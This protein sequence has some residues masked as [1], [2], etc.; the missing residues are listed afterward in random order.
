M[1]GEAL[2]GMAGGGAGAG[3]GAAAGGGGAACGGAP[4][5][6]EVGQA[7]ARLGRVGQDRL[8]R[9]G[10]AR[11]RPARAAPAPVCAAR[12]RALRADGAARGAQVERLD[13][14][15]LRETGLSDREILGQRI[16]EV[17][18]DARA[19]PRRARG[20]SCGA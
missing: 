8:R 4:G 14:E 6:E 20:R 19:A 1:S 3:E 18:P 15:V 10:R 11:A 17:P 5:G 13:T 16:M 7:H 9:R 2:T 12:A